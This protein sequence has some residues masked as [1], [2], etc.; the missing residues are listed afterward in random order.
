MNNNEFFLR[1]L[2]RTNVRPFAVGNKFF[3][4]TVSWTLPFTTF[5]LCFDSVSR[6]LKE[7]A[8]SWLSIIDNLA[9]RTADKDNWR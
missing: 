4:D 7:V 8:V 5:D 1:A 6:Y 2:M 3:S 9:Y